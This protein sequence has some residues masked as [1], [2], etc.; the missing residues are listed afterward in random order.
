[1]PPDSSG[2]HC[3]GGGAEKYQKLPEMP[4]SP[5]ASASLGQRLEFYFLPI[6][7]DDLS[8]P[9]EHRFLKVLPSNFNLPAVTVDRL[10]AAGQKLLQQS[11]EYWRRLR[12]LAA[13]PAK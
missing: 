11:P 4:S 13:E 12:A 1:M 10:A 8:V 9:E 7:Y 3:C 6:G 2:S 5:P